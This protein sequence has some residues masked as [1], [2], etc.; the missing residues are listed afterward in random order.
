[1][2][3]S[4]KAEVTRLYHFGSSRKNPDRILC[5]FF[6]KSCPDRCWTFSTP[7]PIVPPIALQADI[8]PEKVINDGLIGYRAVARSENLGGLVVLWWA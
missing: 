1:M 2:K 4:P 8:A 5:I 3:I 6:E 7:F